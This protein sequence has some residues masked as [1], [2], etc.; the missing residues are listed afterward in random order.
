MKRALKNATKAKLLESD[1]VI[2]T[3]TSDVL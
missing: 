1:E 3:L 2:I